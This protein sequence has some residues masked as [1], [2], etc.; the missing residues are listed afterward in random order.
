MIGKIE[1]SELDNR[2]IGMFDSGIGGLTVL[3]EYIKLMPNENFIYY[4]DTLHLPYGNKTKEEIISYTEKI[5]EFFLANNVKAVVIA[6]GTA[7][8]LAYQHL[9]EKYPIPIFDII[10]PTANAI[11]QPKIG[12]IATKGSV[13]SHVWENKIREVNPNVTIYT[14]ACPKLVP[15]AEKG[16]SNSFIARIVLKKYLKKF[17]QYQIDA[18]ILRLYTLSTFFRNH[19]K[20][21]RKQC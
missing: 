16:L 11:D 2:P 12:I 18:L 3:K 8:S 15:L 4:A 13:N 10:T 6:C 9:K 20:R 21:I 17:K 5:L 19:P 7:S 14:K 1:V